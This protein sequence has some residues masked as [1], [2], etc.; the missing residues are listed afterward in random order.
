MMRTNR[1]RLMTKEMPS[2]L[3]MTSRPRQ[4]PEGRRKSADKMA[5][6]M[7]RMKEPQQTSPIDPK[8]QIS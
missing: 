8:Y 4:G 1:M 6:K 7:R 5:K 2:M 3:T